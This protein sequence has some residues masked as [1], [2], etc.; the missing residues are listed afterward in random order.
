MRAPL[1]GNETDRLAALYA[2]DVLDSGPEKDFDDIVA[3]ASTVCGVPTA[4]VS[5]I[6][7][8]RQWIKARV[9]T[10]RTGTDRDLSFCAH[11]ILGKTLLV[12]PDARQDPRFA[13]NPLVTG[14]PFI[15]FYAGAP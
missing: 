10:G 2:L 14:E 1:P 4:L 5:L 6:D 3:L 8:D 7:M 15:R 12:V 11:A 13:A 9:G